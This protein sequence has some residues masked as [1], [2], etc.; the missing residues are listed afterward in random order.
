MLEA[1]GYTA[2]TMDC[3]EAALEYCRSAAPSPSIAIIDLYMP[4]MDGRTCIKELRGLVHETRLVLTSGE[5]MDDDELLADLGVD[6]GL[7]KPFEFATLRVL[8]ERLLDA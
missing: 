4:G 5:A 8:M 6:G 2:V 7:Q 1:L 3:G